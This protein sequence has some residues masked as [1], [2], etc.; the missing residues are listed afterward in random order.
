MAWQVVSDTTSPM[1]LSHYLSQN[2]LTATA[3]AEKIGRHK[4]TVTRILRGEMRP[5]LDTMQRILDE[6]AGQVTP[7]DFFDVQAS[8][9]G[10]AA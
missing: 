2:E 5:D 6:T 1:Q 10:E 4:S 7:N 3:F 9:D 8:A